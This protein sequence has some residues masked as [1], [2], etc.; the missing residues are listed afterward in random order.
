VGADKVTSERLEQLVYN[1][2]DARGKK[3]ADSLTKWFRP[4][5]EFFGPQRMV[6]IKPMDLAAYVR[7]R[8]KDGAAPGTVSVEL[9]WFRRGFRLAVE[10]DLLPRV[11]LFPKIE[12]DNAR[13][14]F[15]DAPVVERLLPHV[16]AYLRPVI[17]TALSSGWR[18]EAIL[19]RERALHLDLEG[20]WLYL[21]RIWLDDALLEALRAQDALAREIALR[22]G[23][24]VPW[25]FFYP[26]AGRNNLAGGRILNFAHAWND[27]KRAAGLPDVHFHDLRRGAI[28]TLRRARNTEGEIM[29][30]AGLKTPAVFRRYDI[31]DEDDLV[32]IGKRQQRYQRKQAGKTVDFRKKP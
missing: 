19:S 28:R 32:E 8:A 17:L 15:A 24:L 9:A 13:M 4:I 20:R 6:D 12:V 2:L 26:E 31:V 21:V 23:R 22:T 25:V 7:Q 11:P 5:H 18:K 27:A 10:S 16:P 29:Q 14:V 30:W 1:D 3:T